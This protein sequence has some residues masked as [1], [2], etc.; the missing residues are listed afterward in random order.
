M[1][2]RAPATPVQG[3]APINQPAPS[4]TAVEESPQAPTSNQVAKLNSS[5]RLP[6]LEYDAKVQPAAYTGQPEEVPNPPPDSESAGTASPG[7]ESPGRRSP[8]TE[9][10]ETKPGTTWTLE[11]LEGLALGNNPSLGE[12]WARVQAAEGRWIQAGL[13]PNIE[14]GY[15]G[16]QLGSKGQAE[17]EGVFIGQ[18]FVRLRK[19]RLSRAVAA[20]E[21]QV[22]QQQLSAQQR[23]V[24]TDVRLGYYEVLAAQRRLEL[25]RALL[26]INQNAVK[27]AQDLFDI[28]EVGTA[29]VLRATVELQSTQLLLKTTQN[30]FNAAWMRLIAVLGMPGLQPAPV[31]G[32]L[33]AELM[34]VSEEEAL[35]RLLRE[36]PEIYAALAQVQRQRWALDRA[37]A[38][39]LPNLKVQGVVQADNS[40]HSTNGNLQASIPIPWL[41]RNQG[42][43]RE[44]E[45]HVVE[46]ER[47]VG[48]VEL[49]LQ[50]RLAGVY[51]QY[52]SARNTVEIYTAEGGI[53][54]NVKKT[55]DA[56][57]ANYSAGEMSYIDLLTAQRSY[58]QTNLAYIEALGQLRAALAEIEGLLLKDSLSSGM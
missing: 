43:I 41:N 1:L 17:Q 55:L 50:R 54:E 52:A 14:L 47:A 9:S 10:R 18:E 34:H 49:N 2:D 11:E 15:S 25:T 23:R 3:T 20:Q 32:D 46:A 21:I 39:P 27:A 33:N 12:A 13:P 26:V 19:L 37:R 31:A 4:Y 40:T 56:V 5:R 24:L 16:Q 58:A 53:L 6:Q 22:A 30:A 45:F 28:K 57:Q 29:D 35:A 38:E 44:A 51:Q 8:G 48:R 36:S 7:T 42:G